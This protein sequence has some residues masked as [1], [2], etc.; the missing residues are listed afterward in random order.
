MN[1]DIYKQNIL[2]HY[3]SPHNKGVL[4]AYQIKTEGTNQ[5]CGDSLAMYLSFDENKHIHAASFDG[6]GCAISQSA[7]S[8]LTDKIKG[9]SIEELKVMTPGDIYTMLGITISPGRSKCALLAY[10]TLCDAIKKYEEG[11][12]DKK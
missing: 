3:K 11:K 2:N 10:G 7:A 9:K 1:E 12:E 5:S 4:S 8:M 6:S